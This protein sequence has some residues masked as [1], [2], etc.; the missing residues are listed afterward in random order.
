MSIS[1]YSHPDFTASMPPRAPAPAGGPLQALLKFFSSIWLGVILLTLLFI[2][3]SIGS[4]G[5]P[6]SPMI[7]RPDVWHSVRQL[8]AFEL[9][10]YEW[11]NWWPFDLLIALICINLVVATLRRIPLDALHFGV[12]MIH[13]GIIILALGSVW[14]FGTKV[15]GEAP[16][17][18]RALVIE[19]PGSAP[20]TIAAT[21]GAMA[22]IGAG[23]DQYAIQIVA[24]D[25]NWELLS[26]EKKGQRAY[27][28]S[29]RVFSKTGAFI[30][31]VIADDPSLAT[32]LV[33]TNDP[34]RPVDRAINVVGKP[35]VDEAL[36]LRLEYDPQRWFYLVNSRAVYL[37]EVGS[38]QWIQR[39]IEG[40]PR[41]NDHLAR[42][43][44]AW[45]IEPGV[46][47]PIDPIHVPVPAVDANDPLPGVTFH[48]SRYL[49]YAMLETRWK[50]DQAGPI[51]PRIAITI[52]P[53][54]GEP[55]QFEMV[56]FD[57][58]RSGALED[59]HG[60][61]NVVFTWASSAEDVQRLATRVDPVLRFRFPALGDK[62]IEETITA[63]MAGDPDLPF[64]P[65]GDSGYSYRVQS[66]DDTSNF[67]NGVVGVAIV[68]IKSP[69]KTFTRWVFADPA[70]SRDLA[71]HDDPA[72]QH[73]AQMET[74]A[75]IVSEYRKGQFPPAPVVLVAGPG[76][77]DLAMIVSAADQP[78]AK[79][80]PLHV[81]AMAPI[82]SSVTLR[83]DRYAPRSVEHQRP[84]L[85]PD[86][87]RDRSM[88][89]WFSMICL[90]LPSTSASA[91][92]PG[93]AIWL[94]HHRFAFATPDD[95]LRRFPYRPSHFTFNGKTYEVMFSRARLPLPAPVALADF[96]VDTHIGGFTG[97]T[98]SIM[99]WMSVIRFQG[100]DGQWLPEQ[101]VRVNQPSEFRG[102]WFFQAQW[103]PPDPARGPGD[104]NSAGLNYTVLGVGNRHG[105]HVQL[106]GCVIAVLGMIYHWYLKPFI[107][108]R[109]QQAVYAQLREAPATPTPQPALQPEPEAAGAAAWRTQSS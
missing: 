43:D 62:V 65:I 99:D 108:R 45:P 87:Q 13:S 88:G 94:P 98:S 97:D 47:L 70:L 85:V 54:Q 57:P 104:V 46:S 60:R 73:N 61:S 78:Q 58:M 96:K 26:G 38:T 9:T 30:R 92:Q 84:A 66:L 20:V 44:D 17:T 82:T 51:N 36:K 95:V 105:V 24:I 103:D 48:V 29:I 52:A 80:T 53:P 68:Q 75:S 77:N 5:V 106:A 90:D 64:K 3:C 39:P 31:D 56:A 32:D 109:R 101:E 11:F 71:M 22:S 12:W 81:G 7:W 42:P 89:E 35:L 2:Y 102:Y 16:I 49:Q 37:R 93:Q 55:R 107:K 34:N 83:V 69:Q 79:V 72:A 86:E 59:E 6:S 76:E 28:A 8:P 40:L 63:T 33:A 19:A 10:E 25:P 27:K 18:R 50:N 91:D 21:P 41:Y 67:G 100:A 74:D 4:S 14:Y 23:D 15:E 1:S